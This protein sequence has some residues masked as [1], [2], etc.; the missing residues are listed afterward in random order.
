MSRCNRS[1]LRRRGLGGE[2]ASLAEEKKRVREKEAENEQ[3]FV[4]R[5]RSIVETKQSTVERNNE[6]DRDKQVNKNYKDAD[7][8][9]SP[10]EDANF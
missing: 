8:L 4:I 7:D 2:A 1:D 3:N 9:A 10:S 5:A 6:R